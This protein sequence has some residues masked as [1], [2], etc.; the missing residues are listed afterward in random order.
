MRYYLHIVAYFPDNIIWA[1]ELKYSDTGVESNWIFQISKYHD[2]L[3]W[4]RQLG[5]ENV[6]LAIIKENI[7]FWWNQPKHCVYFYVYVVALFF[8][9]VT[10]E[11]DDKWSQPTIFL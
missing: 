10:L 8:S 6:F 11:M 5:G 9:S 4:G 1:H 3:N 7:C 2:W